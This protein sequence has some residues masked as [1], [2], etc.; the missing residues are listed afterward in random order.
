MTLYQFLYSTAIA[1]NIGLGLLVMVA[2]PKRRLNRHFLLFTLIVALWQ[3][4]GWKILHSK[5]AVVADLFIR[6]ASVVVLFVPAQCWI[7][8]LSIHYPT[9]SFRAF[10]RRI[11]P[12]LMVTFLLA[13]L[14]LTPFFIKSVSFVQSLPSMP[15][16][17]EP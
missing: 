7:M 11:R 12:F 8:G 14:P 3:I 10:S 2:N 15:S 13:G 5:D 9:D 4:T 17:A 1:V 6:I 16:I